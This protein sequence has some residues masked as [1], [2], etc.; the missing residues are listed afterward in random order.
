M[1]GRK[2]T[3]ISSSI[4]FVLSFVL[5]ALTCSVP[6]IYIARFL[7]GFGVGFVMTVQPMYIGEISS[8][9]TRNALGAFMQLFIV[10]KSIKNICNE[11]SNFI[12]CNFS[13]NSLRICY[14]SIRIL[15]G[16]P[17]FLSGGSNC[18]HS[19]I[20]IFPRQSSV[21][22]PKGKKRGCYQSFAILSR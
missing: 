4:F 8:D 17:I 15:R 3:L 18:F 10:R 11:Y 14:W 2:L 19:C 9:D 21:L 16:F 22:Y 1:F 5:L 20:H 13:R 7:Q 12:S 6:Q